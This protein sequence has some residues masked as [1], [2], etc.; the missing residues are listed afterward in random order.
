V[1]QDVHTSHIWLKTKTPRKR[2]EVN[3]E[4]ILEIK[5]KSQGCGA[6]IQAILDGWSQSLKFGSGSVDIICGRSELYK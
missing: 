5:V 6:G 1:E 3:E 2:Q 4:G